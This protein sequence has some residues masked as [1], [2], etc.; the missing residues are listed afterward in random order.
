MPAALRGGEDVLQPLGA[1]LVDVGAGVHGDVARGGVAPGQR[2]AGRQHGAGRRAGRARGLHGDAVVDHELQVDGAVAPIAV[3]AVSGCRPS[4]R[5]M[6]TVALGQSGAGPSLAP[7]PPRA[8]GRAAGAAG[9]A[10]RRAA[11]GA[12]RAATR[13]SAAAAGAA[14]R[15]GAAAAAARGAARGSAAAA[16]AAARGAAAGAAAAAPAGAAAAARTAGAA[17]RRCRP[18]RR[19]RR[20]PPGPGRRP[21]PRSLHE[22][23]V[24]MPSPLAQALVGHVPDL[25][26]GADEHRGCRRARPARS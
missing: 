22:N 6:T 13:G 16:G 5:K 25:A 9:A 8:A 2:V 18:C 7:L 24:V 12:A 10:C 14:A 4:I 20:S 26:L 19:P 23:S 11:A 15:A 3:R 21:A 1:G 17:G